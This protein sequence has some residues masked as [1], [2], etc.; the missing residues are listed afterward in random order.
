MRGS[1]STVAR[2]SK[3]SSA[4]SSTSSSTEGA[5]KASPRA[6]AAR[7]AG[8]SSRFVRAR[9]ARV[10]LS[11]G[12]ERSRRSVR[13]GSSVESGA[14]ISEPGASGRGRTTFANRSRLCSMSRTARSTTGTGQR[15]FTCRSTRRR[16]GKRRIQRE[17]ATHVGQAPTVDRLVVVAHEEDPMGR[18]REQERQTELRAVDV[19]DLVDKQMGA[20]VAP[21]GAQD[22]DRRR[23][24][25]TRDGPGRRSPGHRASAIT[26]S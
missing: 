24:R 8:R 13:D 14:R 26:R 11:S 20:M 7:T 21:P 17:D 3:P 2:A 6:S 23:E 19:L 5:R 9:M 12:H 4:G 22:P 18:C 16:P 10:P 15:W 25:P 1:V